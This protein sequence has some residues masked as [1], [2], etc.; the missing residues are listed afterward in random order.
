MG[1]EEFLLFLPQTELALAQ[2]IAE[3]LRQHIATWTLEPE[4]L[5]VTVSIGV[6]QA[7]AEDQAF[8]DLL[9]RTDRA[10]YAAKAA[11][12]NR[13]HVA[14]TAFAEPGSLALA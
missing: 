5:S 3:R 7:S 13:V 6:A 1:G 12:R 2:A 10:L 8:D 14:Q 4:H 9:I 11:G